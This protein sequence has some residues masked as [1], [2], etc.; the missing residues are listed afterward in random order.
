LP[1]TIDLRQHDTL[2]E[3]AYPPLAEGDYTLAI[4]GPAVKDRA[5]NP[6]AAADVTS[7][8]SI[9]AAT[10]QP[11]IRWVNDAG[12]SWNDP[13]NW[14]DAATNQPRL[15]TATDDV[16]ID[17]PTD[18][19]ITVGAGTFTVNSVISNERFQI[20]GGR[21]NVNDTIQVNNTFLLDG[22][23]TLSPG[24]LKGTVLRG[25]GGQG[26]TVQRE[27]R[28][29]AAT[30]QT[31]I[32]LI[33]TTNNVAH[34]RI[35][36]DLALTG[37]L[38]AT[39]ARGEIGIEGT[40]TI[41]SGTFLGAGATFD[42]GKLYFVPVGTASVTLGQDVLVTGN[43]VMWNEGGG[44]QNQVQNLLSVI[45][46][47]TIMAAG[48]N[49]NYKFETDADSF[50]NQGIINTDNNASLLIL[51]KTWTNTS[52][53]KITANNGVF[54]PSFVSV[55]LGGVSTASWT[56]AGTIEL[57]NTTAYVMPSI[58]QPNQTWSNTGTIL[59]NHS[60]LSLQGRFTSDDLVN[61]R[62]SG[63]VYIN[64]RMD[65]VG[66]TFTFNND[67]K[68]IFLSTHGEI[69]G[70]T[71]VSTGPTSR[72]EFSGD[73]GKL[74]GV[75]IE[76]DLELGDILPLF[77]DPTVH[78]VNQA[79]VHVLNGLTLH[80][81]ITIHAGAAAGVSFD[82]AQTVS[83]GTYVF[84]SFTGSSS[85]NDI[86]ASNGGPV[87]FDSTVTFRAAGRVGGVQGWI[88][89]NANFVFDA[90]SGFSL[91]GFTG[92]NPAFTGPFI[93][94]SP[95]TI[96]TG[97]SVTFIS[98]GASVNEAPVNVPGGK[99]TIDPRQGFKN[100]NVID[101]TGGGQLSFNMS[102][103]VIQPLKLAD[104]GTL[105]D[106]GG[107]VSIEGT[108]VLDITG[109]TLAIDGTANWY[110][111]GGTIVGG[112]IQVDSTASFASNGGGTL[113]DV[114]VNGNIKLG[115]GGIMTLVGDLTFN[116]TFQ[117]RSVLKFGDS[118]Y[119]NLPVRIHAGILDLSAITTV[120]QSDSTTPSITLDPGVQLFGV[121][122]TAG[123]STPILNQGLI[124]S[125]TR[126]RFAS[127]R[128]FS[129]TAAPITNQG[130]LKAADTT[131]L[132]IAVLAAPNSGLVSATAGSS[133]QFTDAFA[134]A[135]TGTTHVD[136]GGTTT[137]T[138]GLIAVTGAAT[139]AGTFDVNF[140]AG[141]TPVAGNR[142]QVLNYGS[143]TGQ[144]DTIN[145]TGL[146]AGLVVT[147]EYN[148]TNMTLV[149]S[150]AP[151]GSL[152]LGRAATNSTG[153][154]DPFAAA[155]FAEFNA[156]NSA[157]QSLL[158]TTSS[159]DRFAALSASLAEGW[160]TGSAH[161]VDPPSDSYPSGDEFGNDT[162]SSTATDEVFGM[163]NDKLLL[164]AL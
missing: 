86:Q 15:P 11:T 70:G 83:G 78:Y 122:A 77:Y 135:A 54:N 85:G 20:V 75:T 84:G 14:R 147:P 27:A 139:L 120:F 7:T 40:E 101:L 32:N 31:D 129:F 136:I 164:N 87:V 130:T 160:S 22:T 34:L 2:L 92:L 66:R 5:G 156:D 103:D 144:F 65:N 128:T 97:K 81:T 30:V 133:V 153:E 150:A 98:N 157:A 12:G 126:G 73:G 44:F 113:K 26:I 146:A 138:F 154:A 9:T 39:G 91:G 114:T 162:D 59:V 82:G 71:L 163:L 38:T 99:L 28:L 141:F 140:N 4:N 53:G 109:T 51:A 116:G 62:N 137:A 105:V 52:T 23:G 42:T 6:L 8:F 18:A 29:D 69:V 21:L 17:V 143:H 102:N 61:I 88:T 134:Q 33:T 107:T 41:S 76:G 152:I 48:S 121:N 10:R 93:N 148:G 46:Q 45:N 117:N 108:T 67:T 36:N 55:G 3:I 19:Q 57:N 64:G 110:T 80:G 90:N 161:S 72:L 56:N 49:K 149:V 100:S 123:F 104:I 127:T 124:S 37:T 60:L 142:F 89:N 106:S 119:P 68:S 58:P 158:N 1:V 25:T 118:K 131:K 111:N 16:M 50:I 95:L 155:A 43:V 132:Q 24:T 63:E 94:R 13:N 96:G 145:V 159:A 74:N 112:T 151:G 125:D 79:V 35:A 115:N 47:G